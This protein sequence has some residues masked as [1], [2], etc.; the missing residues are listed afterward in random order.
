MQQLLVSYIKGIVRPELKV[1]PFTTH[2][3]FDGGS[4]DI[5]ESTSPSLSF[6]VGDESIQ[7]KL[8]V[9]KVSNGVQCKMSNGKHDTPPVCLCC[10]PNI[11]KIW[12]SHLCRNSDFNTKFVAKLSTV[13]SEPRSCG[14]LESGKLQSHVN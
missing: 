14:S 5:L 10:N 6:T 2:P 1:H 3:I 12:P 7:W 4:G 9:A 13:A 11:W 8:S